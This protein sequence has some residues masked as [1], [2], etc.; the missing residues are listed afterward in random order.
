MNK[1]I[2]L[3]KG[4]F[5]QV[6][7]RGFGKGA[8]AQQDCPTLEKVFALC[9]F[10]MSL[11]AENLFAPAE[12]HIYIFSGRVTRPCLGWSG[13]AS[14]SYNYAFFCYRKPA[15]QSVVP[16]SLSQEALLCSGEFSDV[17][18]SAQHNC[19]WLIKILM[20]LSWKRSRTTCSIQWIHVS[21]TSRQGLPSRN[22]SGSDKAI[23]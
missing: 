22:F 6:K 16:C 20:R 11:T 15:H 14:G 8:P 17:E 1:R 13:C 3:K 9:R 19:T 5:F 2:L 23:S 7:S 4:W 10:M 18:R 12:K 21:R